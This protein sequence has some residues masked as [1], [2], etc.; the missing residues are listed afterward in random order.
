MQ[1]DLVEPP[2]WQRVLQN[3]FVR[4]FVMFIAVTLVYSAG[5]GSTLQL[6]ERLQQPFLKL[7]GMILTLVATYL[8]YYGLVRGMEGRR[9]VAELSLKGA[10]L[11]LI[12]GLG[13]G[14]GLLALSTLLLWLFEFYKVDAV[15]DVSELFAARH[16]PLSLGAGFFEELAFRAIL[17]RIVEEKL[18]S[19]IA[20][21]ISSLFFGIVHIANPNATLFSS[22]AIAVEAGILLCA[23]YMLTRRVWFAVGIHI[24]WN[25]VQGAVF[26]IAVSGMEVKGLISSHLEGNELFSGGAFGAE[27][28][29][30]TLVVCTTAGVLLLW[31][32]HQNGMFVQPF[33]KYI[34]PIT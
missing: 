17:F 4:F 7:I 27:A 12:G 33:W 8:V 14:A 9:Y 23:A 15:N 11:E 10:L 31:K 3:P 1:Y 5:F 20:L 18:G 13:I 26:G 30:I 34:N 29:L 19:W 16:I 6:A 22:V 28:S 32:S 21:F 25:Y 2:F 24:A